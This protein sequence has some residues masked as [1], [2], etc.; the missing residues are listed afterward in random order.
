MDLLFYLSVAITIFG[1]TGT[2]K[3]FDWYKELK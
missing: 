2:F 1:S 3:D